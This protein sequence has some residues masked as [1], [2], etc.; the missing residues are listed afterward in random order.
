METMPV[1]CRI[2]RS[3]TGLTVNHGM[4]SA[5]FTR[6]RS[7]R[8]AGMRSRRRWTWKLCFL[9]MA[10]PIQVVF[11]CA[12]PAVVARFW[13]NALGYHLQGPPEPDAEWQAWL[14]EHG[15]PE[16]QW[17]DASAIIDPDG[18]G[19]RIYFQ[20]VPEPKAVKNRLHLDVNA[21]GPPGTP[22]SE[23]RARVDQAVE[24]LAT[25]GATLVS[26]STNEYGEHCVTML[27]PEGNEFDV[28]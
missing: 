19:P 1:A 20:R 28:Q 11:D 10:I 18:N 23:R 26:A 3:D 12:N 17:N 8:S 5:A 7:R 14:A 16:E 4:A 13:A 22:P 25:A 27:A 6:S 24:T 9:G 21:G 2:R 15:V